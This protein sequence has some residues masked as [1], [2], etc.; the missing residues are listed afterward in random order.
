MDEGRATRTGGT[1][2]L[3]RGVK[4]GDSRSGLPKRKGGV[5]VRRKWARLGLACS[6]E[7]RVEP[8]ALLHLD[9]QATEPIHPHRLN[10]LEGESADPASWDAG[11]TAWY[12]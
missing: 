5:P 6:A 2:A 3:R 9:S 8:L 1:V 10:S 11:Q 7:P 4:V 12:R